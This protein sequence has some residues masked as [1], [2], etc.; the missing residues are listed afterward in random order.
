MLQE[1]ENDGWE[2]FFD[3]YSRLIYATSCKAGLRPVEAEDVVQEVTLRVMRYIGGF[4]YDAVN[5]RFKPWL[6]RIVRSC[7]VNE[8]RRRDKAKALSDDPNSEAAKD[9]STAEVGLA[10]VWD[11]EWERNL[12]TLALERVRREAAPKQYQLFDLYV[13]QEQPAREIARKLKVSIAQVYMAKK[14]VGDRVLRVAKQLERESEQELAGLRV[15]TN[16]ETPAG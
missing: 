13:L 7:I 3:Q 4:E 6:L 15:A 9:Q 14:R 10:T 8:V 2:R 11:E 16:R 12:F 1:N 5:R